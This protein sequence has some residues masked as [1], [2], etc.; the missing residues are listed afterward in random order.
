M[1]IR[2]YDPLHLD[3]ESFARDGACLDG[4]WPLIELERLSACAAPEEPVQPEQLVHWQLRGELRN[5]RGND[6]EIWLVLH[7][8]TELSM[9][10]QRC[11]KPVRFP[12][13]VVQN[14]RFVQGEEAAA[15]LDAESEDDVLALSRSLDA[16]ALLEDELLLAL[17]LIPKHERCPEPLHA[18]ESDPPGE[19]KPNPFAVLAGWKGA[20]TD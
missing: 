6:A 15:A 4:V 3:V 9:T 1:R 20:G 11:L 7:A 17:P 10:C 19:T 16:R 12:V 8:Q 14:L 18:A 5:V 2:H 13:G